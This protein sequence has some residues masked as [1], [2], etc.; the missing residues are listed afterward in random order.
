MKKK[1]SEHAVAIAK[2]GLN[3]IPGV[4]GSIA[5]LVDDYAPKHT[6]KSIDQALLF[7]KIKLQ[8]L[9][10]RIDVGLADKD[11]FMELFKNCAAIVANTPQKEKL[12][13]AAS[14][15][16][17][18]FLKSGD[19]EKLSYNEIDHFTKCIQNL[20]IGA[21][22]ALSNAYSIVQAK[23]NAPIEEI[24]FKFSFVELQRRMLDY[25]PHLLMGLVG[26]LNTQN[27]FHIWA[28][29]GVREVNYENVPLELTPLGV[30]FVEYLLDY[31]DNERTA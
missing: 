12:Q 13:S 14:L 8:I 10:N 17:N 6:Q 15:I 20:S 30:K 19:S 4:G 18:I 2:A 26:E 1:S 11:E 7:L 5:S 23:G 22:C 16:A 29:P 28:L 31:E 25:D 24:P 9:E 3:L 21:F 27:L